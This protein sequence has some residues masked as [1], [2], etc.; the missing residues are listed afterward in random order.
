M[1]SMEYSAPHMENDKGVKGRNL[2]CRLW[3]TATCCLSANS[4]PKAP[5]ARASSEPLMHQL[6]LQTLNPKTLKMARVY[7]KT[8]R[9]RSRT[10]RDSTFRV[11]VLFLRTG[12]SLDTRRYMHHILHVKCSV[13]TYI[14]IY[15]DHISLHNDICL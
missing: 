12:V 11:P 1:F 14:Y 2:L 15:V 3:G 13:Y 10:S 7:S 9:W 4:R 5:E 8:S 6:S